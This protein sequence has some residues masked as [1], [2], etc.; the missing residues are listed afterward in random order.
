MPTFR[1][2]AHR[3]ERD[4]HPENTLPAFRSALELGACCVE[5]DVQLCADQT[6]VVLHDD[7]LER[8]CAVNTT[9]FEI[10]RTQLTTI[11]AHEPGRL[12]EAFHPTP[13]PT[14][15]EVVTLFNDHPAT[16]VFVELKRASIR[17]FSR[18]AM[19]DAVMPELA[20]ARFPWHLI[21]FDY[22]ILAQARADCA[23]HIGWVL[24]E[25]PPWD[26]ALAERLAP[27]YLFADLDALRQTDG[28]LWP[29]PW[30][31]AIYGVNDPADVAPLAAAGA[32]YLETDRLADLLPL[33][34]GAAD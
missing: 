32:R 16:E 27:E 23:C 15:R 25:E 10:S 8:C 3:G 21:S 24:P 13:I 5:F 6:P 30:Q 18:R 22:E 34:P 28:T 31:W 12:G 33:Q 20:R 9:I 19:L 14:L 17:R 2:V 4:Q 11:S 26:K 1:F 29:G 7:N